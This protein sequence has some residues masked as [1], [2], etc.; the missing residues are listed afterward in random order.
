MSFEYVVEYA[1]NIVVLGNDIAFHSD[2]YG[3]EVYRNA[4]KEQIDQAL[5]VAAVLVYC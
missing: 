4:S 1:E 3:T 2:E 5:I